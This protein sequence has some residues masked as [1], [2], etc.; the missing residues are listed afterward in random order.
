MGYVREGEERGEGEEG[1]EKNYG[2]SVAHM[3]NSDE[4]LSQGRELS[5]YNWTI[6]DI[7]G[8]II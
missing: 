2:S 5:P 3:L 4:K 7:V 8:H 6:I 1:V